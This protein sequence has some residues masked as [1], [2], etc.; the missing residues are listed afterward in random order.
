M[1]KRFIEFLALC[2]VSPDRVGQEE[3]ADGSVI[4]HDDAPIAFSSE[5]ERFTLRPDGVILDGDA[6]KVGSL[7]LWEDWHWQAMFMAHDAIEAA[8]A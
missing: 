3:Q 1:F 4:H 6:N 8:Q 7:E 5:G 2:G